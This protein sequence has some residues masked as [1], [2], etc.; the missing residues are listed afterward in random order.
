MHRAMAA[1]EARGV[2]PVA[3][4]DVCRPIGKLTVVWTSRDFPHI[5]ISAAGPIH[6]RSRYP[7]LN[8]QVIIAM[9][10]I[11]N[12]MIITTLVVRLTS[13]CS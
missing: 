10:T 11:V 3:R 9:G 8:I 2:V 5:V 7:V 1:L 6:F 13:L 12:V 4:A